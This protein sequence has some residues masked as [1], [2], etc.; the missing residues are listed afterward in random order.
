MNPTAHLAAF[1][2]SAGTSTSLVDEASL[3][4]EEL[5][6]EAVVRVLAGDVQLL[7]RDEL[8]SLLVH[9]SARGPVACASSG[10]RRYGWRLSA[11]P[12]D[13]ELTVNGPSVTLRLDDETLTAV[14][15][16]LWPALIG[17]GV[18]YADRLAEALGADHAL[19]RRLEAELA[20]ARALREERGWHVPEPPDGNVIA[21]TTTSTTTLASPHWVRVDP[22]V[23]H[24]EAR[25][26]YTAVLGA[27]DEVTVH[28]AD[29]PEG[30]PQWLGTL[31][32]GHAGQTDWL[33]EGVIDLGRCG[34]DSV[35]MDPWG[36][37]FIATKSGA[38]GLK[39]L[40]RELFSPDPKGAA[41]FWAQLL[42]AEATLRDGRWRLER[43]GVHVATVRAAEG[44]D[45]GRWLHYLPV[46]DLEAAVA[47]ATGAGAE[48]MEESEGRARMVDPFGAVFGLARSP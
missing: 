20:P 17:V 4:T 35:W 27:L 5:T 29:G 2:W 43:G 21:N 44:G 28:E 42:D 38:D 8:H 41:A 19:V 6:G 14:G 15:D 18:R 9:L 37:T 31:D 11:T 12:S 48:V 46:N 10:E 39:A 34:P 13:A 23:R 32:V 1:R 47:R 24:P 22:W 36:A 26:F 25:A 45:V 16:A 30:P 3:T 33:E 40:Y 7:F